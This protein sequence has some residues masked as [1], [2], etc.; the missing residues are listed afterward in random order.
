[1]TTFLLIRHGATDAIGKRLVSRS[2]HVML[3]A[4]GRAQVAELAQRLASLPIAAVYSSPLER[5]R[6]TAEPIARAHQLEVRVNE[7]LHEF[8]FGSWTG[9]SLEELAGLPEWQAFNQYRSLTRAPGGESM[10][11]VQLRMVGLLEELTRTHAQALVALVSHGDPLRA[12][13]AYYLGVPLD[14]FQRIEI[15]PASASVITLGQQG[16]R[17]LRM[18]V[19]GRIV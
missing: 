17:V 13:L 2:P 1:M 16:A 3:N 15:Q 6:A 19:N 12:L 5:A 10:L 7:A 18:N 9:K 8:E 4:E 11:E 14:L